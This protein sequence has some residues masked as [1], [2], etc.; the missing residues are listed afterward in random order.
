MSV[1][2]G[3]AGLTFLGFRVGL[4]DQHTLNAS[5][6]L[7]V[8]ASGCKTAVAKVWIPA[9][10]ATARF[11]AFG[12][13]MLGKLDALTNPFSPLKSWLREKPVLHSGIDRFSFRRRTVPVMVRAFSQNHDITTFS[14]CSER[15][16]SWRLGNPNFT[17]VLAGILMAAPVAGFLPMRALAF[18]LD[19][20]PDAGKDEE[21][22]LLDL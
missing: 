20:P 7:G 4:V 13:H 18:R 17:T 6:L 8:L 15:W 22:I 11:A 19:Q 5:G 16:S 10:F 1:N 9:S 12:N 21:A 14:P 3:R 2:S